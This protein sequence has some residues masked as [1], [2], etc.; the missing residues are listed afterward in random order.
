MYPSTCDTLTVDN[1]HASFKHFCGVE[2]GELRTKLD[3]NVDSLTVN[4]FLLYE[5][6]VNLNLYKGAPTGEGYTCGAQNGET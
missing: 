3:I 5:V 4:G 6:S 2:T 1:A